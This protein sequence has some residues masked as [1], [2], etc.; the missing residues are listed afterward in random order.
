M[1]IK[2]PVMEIFTS[3]QGE[4]AHMGKLTTFIRLAGCNLTCPWCDTKVS[5]AMPCAHKIIKPVGDNVDQAVC[6]NC[7]AQ[8]TKNE[9][10]ELSVTER[11][12]AYSWVALGELV[13]H[14]KSEFVVLT[15]GE[16]T[17][18]NL[19]PLIDVLH[20][21]DCIVALETNGTNEIPNDW[22]LDWITCS[23]KPPAYRCVCMDKVD[24]I[25]LVCDSILT[26]AVAKRFRNQQV[27][28]LIWIQ[29]ESH[30]QVSIDKAIAM[31]REYPWLRMGIQLHKILGV[32]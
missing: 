5:R 26:P 28:D 18:H 2:Y 3:I 16:P 4:G 32:E 29:P 14:I 6:E 30:K 15:G 11:D 23:P 17:L 13:R 10:S 7:G 27:S 31:V 24:E 9:L 8:G 22:S 20:E 12:A 25:K 19:K 1:E 21:M